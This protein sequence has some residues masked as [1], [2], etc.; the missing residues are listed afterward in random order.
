MSTTGA[1]SRMT[2]AHS[3]PES[4]TIWKILAKAGTY[5]MTQCTP[6]LKAM[7]TSR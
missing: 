1:D 7:A 5:R 6:M 3:L 4:G 2:S